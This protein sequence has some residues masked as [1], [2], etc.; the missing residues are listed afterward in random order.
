MDNLKTKYGG[1]DV[2]EVKRLRQLEEQNAKRDGVTRPIVVIGLSER[3][4]YSIVNTDRMLPHPR[5]TA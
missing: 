2:S 1:M 4:A 5:R 3:R